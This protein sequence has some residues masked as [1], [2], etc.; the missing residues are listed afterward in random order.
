MKP[1]LGSMK[2]MLVALLL[3]ALL[4]LA[5]CSPG[6][7]GGELPAG[8]DLPSPTAALPGVDRETG[9]GA[10]TPAPEGLPPPATAGP[11]PSPGTESA[12]CTGSEPH[13]I[14]LSIAGDYD[15][16]YE[17]VMEWFCS[18]YSFENIL[19]ALE[20]GEA[21]DIPPETLLL[22]LLD[23]EWEEIWDEIGFVDQ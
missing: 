8:D 1:V 7:T 6:G 14:G 9:G 3:A 20:T 17:Q 10:G 19:V 18:G 22:M 13:P 21:T 5:A 4:G 16:P 23:M 15:V 12:G 2:R 11:A